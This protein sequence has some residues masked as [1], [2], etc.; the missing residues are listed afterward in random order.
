METPDVGRSHG[1][2]SRDWASEIQM[3]R[4]EEEDTILSLFA[5]KS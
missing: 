2:F 5:T 4:N 3:Y 1:L